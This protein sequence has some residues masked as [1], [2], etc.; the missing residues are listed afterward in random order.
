MLSLKICEECWKKYEGE[1]RIA[2]NR[3]WLTGSVLSCPEGAKIKSG[4][5]LREIYEDPPE[6][7]PFFL[8]HHV[9]MHGRKKT[10]TDIE[11]DW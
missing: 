4:R 5:L 10:R 6:G 2:K 11:V 7:C 9:E 1:S 3:L 8:E